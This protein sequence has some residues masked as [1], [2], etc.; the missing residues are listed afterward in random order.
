MNTDIQELPTIRRVSRSSGLKIVATNGCFDLLHVGHVRYLQFAKALGD[1]LI[2][3]VNSDASV[4]ALKGPGRPIVTCSDRMEMLSALECVDLVCR[5][6]GERCV[7]F[8]A[9]CQP[10]FYVKSSEY[11][12]ESLH[13]DE[14]AVLETLQTRI[15]FAP[16]CEGR[17]TSSLVERASLAQCC[18]R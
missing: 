1:L 11:S 17:S 8:L 2:V 6:D 13:P 18:R 5:F 12:R 10:D 16:H 15:V 9:A 14:V 4:S 3:G 7:D